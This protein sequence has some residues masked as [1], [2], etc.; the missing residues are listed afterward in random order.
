MIRF[1]KHFWEALKGLK[2]NLL[3]SSVAISSVGLTLTLLGLVACLVVNAHRL[4]QGVEGHVKIST[5]LLFNSTDAQENIKN[6]QG[7]MVK[8]PDYHKVYDQIV[9]LPNVA[10]VS[11]S[12]KDEQLQDLIATM[13]DEFKSFEQDNPLSDVYV[14]A[15]TNPEAVASVAQ[16]IEGIEGVE[17]VAYGGTDTETLLEVMAT[18]RLWGAVA[19]GLIFLLA[20]FFIA[21]TIRLTILSRRQEIQIM[22]LVG[23]TSAY[24]RGPFLIEGALIGFLGALLPSLVTYLAYLWA[25]VEYNGQLLDSGLSLYPPHPFIF[26]VLG[27]LL[28]V[29]MLIGSLGSRLSMRKYLKF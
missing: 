23:A 11:F 3:M 28:V 26:F 5:H 15:V 9:A 21:N 17:E 14:V 6:T 19:T 16:A 12:S 7:K 4:S 10:E 29:G 27:G 2:R 20:V 24:I 8:N 1:F 13:G 25:Y 22:R 18:G